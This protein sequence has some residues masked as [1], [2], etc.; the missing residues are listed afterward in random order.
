MGV[1]HIA[2]RIART[3]PEAESRGR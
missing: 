2:L 3:V 1:W